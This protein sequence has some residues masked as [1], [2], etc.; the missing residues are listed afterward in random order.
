MKGLNP[1]FSGSWV[2]CVVIDEEDEEL[3]CLN[4]CFSGSW[5]VCE[6]NPPH[7]VEVGGKS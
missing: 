1:C 4:P 3:N 6:P 2:V 5:V 7:I